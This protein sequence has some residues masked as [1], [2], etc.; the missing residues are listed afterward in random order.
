MINLVERTTPYSHSDPSPSPDSD[1]SLDKSNNSDPALSLYGRYLDN[2]NNNNNNICVQS[3][4]TAV[5]Q[6]VYLIS[7][8]IGVYIYIYLSLSLSHIHTHTSQLITLINPDN[9]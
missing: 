8:L 5:T 9:P 7:E 2:N 1:P 3:A 6:E 4:N